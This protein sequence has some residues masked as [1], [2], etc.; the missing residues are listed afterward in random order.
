[1]EYIVHRDT[2]LEKNNVNSTKL[3]QNFSLNQINIGQNIKCFNNKII[4]GI[5]EHLPMFLFII[6]LS[7]ILFSVWCFYV[8]PFFIFNDM[9]YFPIVQYISFLFGMFFY[10]KCFMTEPGIIPR[11]HYLFSQE[12]KF[13][14]NEKLNK[15]NISLTIIE[16]ETNITIGNQTNLIELPKPRIYT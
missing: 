3:Y 15:S 6:F 8:F 1:M 13:F 10:F 12:R 9:L 16:N 2:N 5:K 4:C 14:D 11:N 7:V